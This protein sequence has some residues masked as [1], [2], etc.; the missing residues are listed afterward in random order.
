LSDANNRCDIIDGELL[1]FTDNGEGGDAA[2][3]IQDLIRTNMNEGIYESL[4]PEIVRLR[5]LDTTPP[6]GESN[7]GDG[8]SSG[9]GVND[10]TDENSNKD[11]RVGLFVGLFAGVAIIAG[12]LYRTKRNMRNIDDETDLQTNNEGASAAPSQSFNEA[13]ISSQSYDDSGMVMAD[14]GM[15]SPSSSFGVNS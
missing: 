15:E 3:R 4:I 9:N 10:G 2:S 14:T 13:G 1:L 7:T 12:V 6:T 8:S 5:Y 11:L